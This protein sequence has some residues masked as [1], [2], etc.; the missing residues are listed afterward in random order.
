MDKL[1]PKYLFAESDKCQL[2]E[3]N[4][5]HRTIVSVLLPTLED[6]IGGKNI[7]VCFTE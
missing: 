6:N 3:S 1:C 2:C 4:I 7:I 5:V